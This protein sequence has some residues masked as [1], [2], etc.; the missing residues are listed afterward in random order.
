MAIKNVWPVLADVIANYSDRNLKITLETDES[1]PGFAAG[2]NKGISLAPGADK[3]WI[4][5]PDTIPAPSALSCMVDKLVSG[6]FDAVGCTIV[7]FD[8]R[9]QS[10]GGFWDRKTGQAISLGNGS[11]S[12]NLISS[13]KVNSIQN[14]L[15]GASF[16]VSRKFVE[17]NGPNE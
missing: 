5:N 13:E 10:Q 12:S 1:N 3:F 16:L 2:V 9:V 7:L 11:S 4:L 8:E 6:E 14:Y 15:N 17:I